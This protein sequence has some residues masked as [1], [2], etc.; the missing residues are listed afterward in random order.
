MFLKFTWRTLF[1][2][3]Q[4]ESPPPKNDTKFN[5][6]IFSLLFSRTTKSVTFFEI[7][8]T[9]ISRIPFFDPGEFSFTYNDIVFQPCFNLN[10]VPFFQKLCPVLSE[11]SMAD[12]D[13]DP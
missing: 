9:D 11:G 1:G 4:L 12:D 3:D 2:V 8:F 5:D 6:W 7:P 13:E 10:G